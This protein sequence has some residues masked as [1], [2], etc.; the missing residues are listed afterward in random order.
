MTHEEVMQ[1]LEELKIPY[2]YDHFAE[3]E[4]PEPPFICFLFSGSDNFSADN[5]VYVEFLNLS[6]ELYTDEKNP[7]LEDQVEAV[8]N[9][10]ELFWNKSEVWI[11]SEKLYEVLYQ[12]TV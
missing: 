12:M 1:M 9:S 8:L 7:E 4:S 3:G 2:A 6:I 11:E 5:I 10:H